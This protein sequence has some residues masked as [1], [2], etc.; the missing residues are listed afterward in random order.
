[1][2]KIILLGLIVLQAF[3][4]SAQATTYL[5]S[6]TNFC[7]ENERIELNEDFTFKLWGDG[8]LQY[9]GTWE[10]DD[11]EGNAINV[12]IE[13]GN[14]SIELHLRV[15]EKGRGLADRNSGD[16]YVFLKKIEYNDAEYVKDD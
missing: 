12:T 6:S 11:D 14:R 9:E 2:K 1:M 16:R 15:T 7:Y 3:V 13:V 10:F 5:S 4:Y 8:I